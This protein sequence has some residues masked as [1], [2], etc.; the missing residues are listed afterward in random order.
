MFINPVGGG[1]SSL[2]LPFA[3]FNFVAEVNGEEL[4]GV[5]FVGVKVREVNEG[6]VSNSRIFQ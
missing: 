6:I 4:G 3:V 5:L 1:G 2:H